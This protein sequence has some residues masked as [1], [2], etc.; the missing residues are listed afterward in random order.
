MH[1]GPAGIFQDNF[2][3]RWNYHLLAAPGYVLV[4]TDYTGST[5]YGEKFSQ[6]IQ[7][8]SF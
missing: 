1:G 5:G 7:I 2:S 6:D 4:L 8:R 3:Y